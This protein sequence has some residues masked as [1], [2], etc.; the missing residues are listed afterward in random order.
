MRAAHPACGEDEA[1]PNGMHRNVI[2]GIT[3][4]LCALHMTAHVHISA[5]A[6]ARGNM[7]HSQLHC[8]SILNS[9]L[10]VGQGAAVYCAMHKVLGR[11]ARCIIYHAQLLSL[12]IQSLQQAPLPCQQQQRSA[13]AHIHRPL[14]CI[15]FLILLHTILVHDVCKQHTIEHSRQCFRPSPCTAL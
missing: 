14:A 5:S 3:M 12:T 13:R 1:G 15:E 9:S 8:R 7:Q 4:S 2:D 11:G 6:T 10:Q